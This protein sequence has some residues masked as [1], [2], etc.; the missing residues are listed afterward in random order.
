MDG[1]VATFMGGATSKAT[2]M[3]LGRRTYENLVTSWEQTDASDP[4]I[5]AMNRVP[6]YLASR[7]HADPSWQ[8]TTRL[9]T[10][11]PADVERLRAQGSGE[12]VVFGSGQLVQTLHELDLVV[13]YRLLIFP[14]EVAITTSW[15]N[16][17]REFV[18]VQPNG[19]RGVNR[20]PGGDV[21][22]A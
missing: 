20:R 15:C 22:H 8:N 6:K 9:G 3:L 12:I 13:E 18:R 16:I 2:G 7:T 17:D 21:G 1:T 5:A 11:L 19:H 10:D 4:A 14:S